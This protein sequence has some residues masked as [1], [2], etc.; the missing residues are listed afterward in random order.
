MRSL[1]MCV[2]WI[3]YLIFTR[4]VIERRQVVMMS[5]RGMCEGEQGHTEFVLLGY[6]DAT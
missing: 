5:R 2:S 4:Y 3:W 1:E 6:A